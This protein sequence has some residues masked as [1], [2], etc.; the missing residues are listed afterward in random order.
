MSPAALPPIQ[1]RGLR[2]NNLQGIDLDLPRGALIAISGVSGS[3]KSS[4]AFDTLYAEGQRRYAECLSSYAR[5]FLERMARPQAESITG[6]P[7]TVALEQGRRLGAARSTVATLTE[8]SEVLRVVFAAGALP[9]CPHCGGQVQRARPAQVA[10]ELARRGAG[11]RAMIAFSMEFSTVPAA[12]AAAQA[13]RAGGYHRAIVEGQVVDFAALPAERW[14]G[15]PLWVLQDRLVLGSDPARE[16]E[17]IAAAMRRG[18]GR[19]EVLVSGALAGGALVGEAPAEGDVASPDDGRSLL[20]QRSEVPTVA[21]ALPLVSYRASTAL[22]CDAC[23]Q[24]VPDPAAELFS[25]STALG[26][27]PACSGFGRT[28]GIDWDKVLP[29]QRLTLAGG[30]IKPWS[31]DGTAWERAQLHAFCAAMAIPLTLPWQDLQA[32]ERTLL[33]DGYEGPLAPRFYGLREWFAWL[34]ART[35]KMHVRVLLSRYRKFLPCAACQ[36]TRLRGE[37][38]QWRLFGRTLPEWLAAPI[39]TLQGWLRDLALDDRQTEILA[40]PLAELRRRIGLLD[41]L[42]LG[43][44]TL[45]RAGRTLSG[46][47]LQRVQLVTALASG[48]SQVL[49]V[50]D[51][52]SVGLHAQDNARLLQILRRLQSAGNTVVFVEHDPALIACADHLVDL[53]PGAGE[54]GGQI[55]FQ[56]P[57]TQLAS[58]RGSLTADYLLGRRRVDAANVSARPTASQGADARSISIRARDLQR[59]RTQSAAVSRWLEIHEPRARNLQG[60]RVRL[61]RGGLNVVCGVSGAGKSSLVEEVLA[62][63]L[64]RQRGVVGEEP[65]ACE[66]IVGAE[67]FTDVIWLQAGGGTASSRANPATLLKVWDAV[68]T[69]LAAEPSA[70]QAGLDASSFSF[71]RPGG[72]CEACEG[73]GFVQVDMQFLSDVRLHCEACDGERFVPAA[74]SVRYRG[75]SA[76]DFLRATAAEVADRFADDERIAAPLR[77]LCE[78]GLGYLR[79]GQP[80]STLSGGEGQRLE[81]ARHLLLARTRNALLLLDEPSTGLHLDDVR[82]LL[83]NLRRL[84]AAGNT[85]VLIEHHLDLIATA[86]HLV[87]LGP[88]G[89]PGGGQVLFQGAPLALTLRGGTPTALALKQ[90]AEGSAALGAAALAAASEPTPALASEADPG[91]VEVRGA[92]VH[93]LRGVDLDL[94][95]DQLVVVTGVS[96]SGKSS[97]AFD[98]IFAE[99]QRRFLDCLSPYA[100]QFLPPTTRPNVDALRGLPPTIAIAQRTTRGGARST[101]GT[102]TEV[103]TAL[104]L[105][106]ARLGTLPLERGAAMARLDVQA[107]AAEARARLPAAPIWVLA[108]LVRQRKGHHAE[109]LEKLRRAGAQWVHIDGAL[110]PLEALP[111]LR[112]HVAHDVDAVVARLPHGATGSSGAAGWDEAALLGAIAEAAARGEGWVRLRCAEGP[113]LQFE[114]DGVGGA[115]RPTSSLDPMLFS[116]TSERG[117]CPS[118][119]G[120]G[121]DAQAPATAE[122]AE[123]GDAAKKGRARRPQGEREQAQQAE[124]LLR[125]GEEEAVRTLRPCPA[126]AGARLRPEALA[127]TVHGHRIDALSALGPAGL[128]AALEA[129]PWTSWQRPVAAPI[130]AEVRSR[131]ELL[132]RL[133]LDYLAFDRPATTLSGGESQRIRLAAQ[134][135]SNLSGVL[136]V[137]DEPTIGL[138]PVDN[139][140]LITAF[141]DLVRRGN[142]LLVVEHDEETIRAADLVVELGP[143]GGER[144]GNLLHVGTPT[145]LLAVSESPTGRLLSDSAQ[146]RSRAAPRPLDDAATLWVR[147][148]TL[149]NLRRVD[150]AFRIGRFNAVIGVSGSGKSTLV[151]DLLVGVGGPLCAAAAAQAPKAGGEPT[152]APWLLP[153]GAGAVALEGLAAFGRIAQ[154]DQRPIGRTPR[155]C[156]ATYIGIFDEIRKVF[157]S[158]PEAKAQGLGAGRFSFNTAGGRCET[159]AGAGVQKVELSFLPTVWVACDACHG[160][161]YDAATLL[162]RHKGA[163]IADV[164]RMS[165]EQAVEHFAAYR[166]IAGPLRLAERVGLGYLRLGQG[167]N[168]LSGGEAQR[169]KLV[170]ELAT[171]RRAA[172]LYVLDE[173]STGL[174]LADLRQLLDVLHEL[175]DRG[176]T[177]IVIEHNLDLIREADWLVELGPGGG[178]AGGQVLFQGTVAEL[179]ATIGGK[180]ETATAALL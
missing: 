47:E 145:A 81:I 120:A 76:S 172:T 130:V 136:Y 151:R 67:S 138:H 24:E 127:V 173:P 6:I 108:P 102:L 137:L 62:R 23:S 118:C 63:N 61:L 99:G 82:V 89:G 94:P 14:L 132:L 80:L 27:C 103:A 131:T 48:L 100:R 146:R 175:V 31:T 87:E 75:W 97:L 154:V 34:E 39:V 29:D 170:A 2:Q 113:T 149:H 167:S 96:G 115:A 17:A 93:N 15:Q 88:V 123:G 13:L 50:L 12:E 117:W 59:E 90:A 125:Q 46:G 171:R 38:L 55:T 160:S 74:L 43:Y 65:G 26:A 72:R 70:E 16:H 135:G 153:A 111:S 32:S 18:G 73:I 64:L 1:L 28:L 22:R 107:I 126:C 139:R 152:D 140:K 168:T 133:G 121:V 53:G 5:Q 101:V 114:L 157:A 110:A 4:L 41:D 179:R 52:P 176:D 162:P 37:V 124:D 104:R 92:R 122:A 35:Y 25:S 155:S 86:D 174:H 129:M 42:G 161:R 19:V 44:L 177:L 54:L 77:A 30:A 158:L 3:G 49:Y 91:C 98:V 106:F 71:N 78:L 9:I 40:Q 163:S 142:G 165:V 36:G 7:P 150:A 166:S 8:V 21:G 56:G 85:V 105:L 51:E 58:A 60:G 180:G 33:V 20:R 109:V 169:L 83:A 147:G 144:G 45:D 95:R 128:L 68:R 79:L 148:A 119:R 141:H 164:L 178:K 156:P 116:F 134:L 69:R 10:A 84:V 143:G 57:L 159:C 11:L 112:R 66:A